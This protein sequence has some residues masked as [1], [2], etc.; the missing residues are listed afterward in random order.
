MQP[1]ALRAA[2]RS[3]GTFAHADARSLGRNRDDSPLSRGAA[4]TGGVLAP[5]LPIAAAI[6]VGGGIGALARWATSIAATATL[7]AQWP[8]GTLV[9]NLAGCLLLGWLKPWSASGASLWLVAGLGVGFCGAYT[10]F[11]TFAVEAVAL[12][13]AS[14]PRAAAA[15]VALS[16][17]GGV[18]CVLVGHYLASRT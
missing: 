13:R 17:V 11:S 6:A 16:V 18:G 15:Y 9:A 1:F 8:V 2:H 10:T 5:S 14:G 7:G 3:K 4:M 12:A